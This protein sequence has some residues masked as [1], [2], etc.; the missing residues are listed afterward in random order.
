MLTISVN[1]V[2][3][4]TKLMDQTSALRF[5]KCLH[6]NPRFTG[7]VVEE[8][9]QAKHPE[10]RWIVVFHPANG[11]RLVEMHRE[12]QDSRAKR[13]EEQ[14]G[15]YAF[16]RDDSGRFFHC[17]NT[18]SGEVYETTEHNCT[19]PDW[20]YRCR[21]AQLSCKHQLMLAAAV[22]KDEVYGMPEPI[23]AQSRDDDPFEPAPLPDMIERRVETARTEPRRRY[24][25]DFG[26]LDQWGW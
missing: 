6:A 15:S 4:R 1:G 7:V 23:G 14:A 19:C 11:D 3:F 8:S 2:Q 12:V 17:F 26:H 24:D 16:I 22:E 13:A 25:A 20:Q 9:R 21:C 10:R 18:V 5:A